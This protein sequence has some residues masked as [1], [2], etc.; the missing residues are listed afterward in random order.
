MAEGSVS[1]GIRLPDVQGSRAARNPCRKESGA[2]GG[3]N[4]T[5][6]HKATPRLNL[7]C[8]LSVEEM[9]ETECGHAPT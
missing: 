8:H 7:Y 9:F 6:R 3:M 2:Q 4:G 5:A 1:D